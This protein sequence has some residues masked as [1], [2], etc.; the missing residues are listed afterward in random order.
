MKE[1]SIIFKGKNN[2]IQIIL[3]N[4]MSFNELKTAFENKIKSAKNFFKDADL[5]ISFK[6]REINELEEKELI[7]IIS[8]NTSINVSFLNNNELK[9]SE[10]VFN[11]LK[12]ITVFHKGSIR[13]GQSLKDNG[14]IVIIGDVNPGGEIIARGNII[15]LGSLKGIA[16]A[17]CDG[18]A[19]CFIAAFNLC[20]MQLRIADFITYFSDGNFN[21]ANGAEIARIKNGQIFI[22]SLIH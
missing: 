15:I 8:K 20:P 16:H 17:G 2:G 6:G 5:S 7:D 21:K 18:N 22:E 14:S 10:K 19:D 4:K 9:T 3:D 12:N 1:N 13:N 11:A